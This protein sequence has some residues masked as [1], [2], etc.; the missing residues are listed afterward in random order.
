MEIDGDF[1]NIMALIDQ[2]DPNFGGY[3]LLGDV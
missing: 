3:R 1:D 2:F